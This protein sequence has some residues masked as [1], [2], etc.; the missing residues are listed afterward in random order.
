MKKKIFQRI[1]NF[2]SRGAEFYLMRNISNK[3]V[4]NAIINL[5][6]SKRGKKYQGNSKSEFIDFK[7]LPTHI[8]N[9]SYNGFTKFDFKLSSEKLSNIISYVDN[10]KCY[11]PYRKNLG[12]IDP[13]NAPLETHTAHYKRLELIENEDILNIANDNGLLALAQEF[14][15][16][17]PTISNIN[18]WWSFGERPQAEEA[19]LY[20]RDVDDW[21]FCK[22]FIY[23]TDVSLENGPHIYVKG[24]SAS[25]KLRKIRRYQDVEIE[26]AFG[27]EN[28]IT[29]VEP[30]GTS[31][32]VDTYGFHK[33]LL[34]KSGRRL[35]LQVQYSL[36]PIAVEKYTPIKLS[37]TKKE[38]D[39]FINRLMIS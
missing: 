37:N 23:L 19:Q 33:G 39:K 27:K 8:N 13:E 11:D 26:N 22:V 1:K 18:M 38:Y 5:I 29:F 16:A 9:M 31:F 20:H 12:D 10:L 32:M 21:K 34:P 7:N 15:G 6:V 2:Q 24:T 14:L 35:L 30:K 28:V 25:P 17:T 4:R 36:N 3:T